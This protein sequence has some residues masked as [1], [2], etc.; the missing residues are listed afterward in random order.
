MDKK[1]F[2]TLQSRMP[3]TLA[4]RAIRRAGLDGSSGWEGA[5]RKYENVHHPDAEKFLI[6]VLRQHALCGEKMTKLYPVSKDTRQELSDAISN[7]RTA[8][9]A[10]TE[11][12]PLLLSE[13]QLE[14]LNSEPVLVSVE[15]TE[16]GI[17]AVY[18][19]VI[20]LTSREEIPISDV[21]EDPDDIKERYDEVIGL[22]F[23]SVQLFNVIWVPHHD[24]FVEVRTDYPKGMRQE[25]VHEIQ[26]QY[27]A[28]ANGLLKANAVLEVPAA[29]YF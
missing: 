28:I 17:G 10:L 11:Q 13:D 3:W 14:E 24:E 1:I 7:L 21:F 12:F 22:K 25:L 2:D 9:H 5:R 20:K 18:S 15:K 23:Q 27:K 26:S 29:G 6:E 8:K 16:D 19:M 4:N